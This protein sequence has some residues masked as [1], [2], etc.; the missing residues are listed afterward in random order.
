MK[1][2]ELYNAKARKDPM[3]GI[4]PPTIVDSD[5]RNVYTIVRFCGI[6]I[7]LPPMDYYILD[8]KK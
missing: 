1:E 2:Q 5:F 3:T 4:V 8:T 6:D 7:F